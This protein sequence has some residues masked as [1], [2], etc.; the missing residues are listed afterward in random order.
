MTM[1]G[2]AG[3]TAG[4]EWRFAYSDLVITARFHNNYSGYGWYKLI[5][6]TM[7]NFVQTTA[8]DKLCSNSG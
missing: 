3:C 5:A 2:H 8:T 1:H 4:Y 7:Y 6:E